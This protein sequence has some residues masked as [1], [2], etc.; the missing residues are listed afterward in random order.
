MFHCVCID[1]CVYVYLPMYVCIYVCIYLFLYPFTVDRN[2]GCFCVLAIMNN[3][4]MNMGVQISLWYPVSISFGYIHRSGIVGSYGS[5]IFNFLR[6]LHTVFHSGCT[7][8]HSH[9]QCTRVPFSSHPRQHLVWLIFLIIAILT[10]VR[11]YLIVI[12]ICIS[13]MISGVE[14]L[15]IYLLTICMSLNRYAYSVLLFIF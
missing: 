1:V 14:H 13:L 15:F 6:K 5:S 9:Q 4:A 2:L 11:W 3:A 12:F 8:L 7:N 10:C